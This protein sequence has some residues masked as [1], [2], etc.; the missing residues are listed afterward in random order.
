[1]VIHPSPGKTSHDLG[2]APV[3]KIQTNNPLKHNL[4]SN[5]HSLCCCSIPACESS[6]WPCIWLDSD[7][8]SAA[9]T[10]DSVGLVHGFEAT[11]ADKEPLHDAACIFAKQF[12]TPWQVDRHDS[13]N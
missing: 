3:T 10:V 13:A 8:F 2:C 12:K 5:L 11:A 9:D 6:P 7:C 4:F 1:M